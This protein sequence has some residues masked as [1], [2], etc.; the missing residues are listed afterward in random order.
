MAFFS[1][2]DI[3]HVLRKEPNMTCLTPSHE[4]KISE[5]SSCTL[6][7]TVDALTIETNSEGCLLGESEDMKAAH[8]QSEV[9]TDILN[10]VKM[11]LF[12]ETNLPFLK[13]Q[14][15]KDYKQHQGPSERGN[16]ETRKVVK[17]KSKP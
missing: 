10:K 16:K 1:A 14:M 13:A 7:D 17:Y 2:V 9:V 15:Y 3:D 12:K 4:E 6:L 5:G 8:I 11:D